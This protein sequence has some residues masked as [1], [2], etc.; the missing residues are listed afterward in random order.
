M[1]TN[2]NAAAP[3]VP[4]SKALVSNGFLFISGQIGSAGGQLVTTSFQDEVRQVFTNIETVL[5]E[6]NLTFSHIV[7]VT[8]Y[9]TDMRYFDELNAVYQTYFTDRYPTRTCI[10][11]AGLPKQARVELTTMA[12]LELEAN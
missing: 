6:H 11:V 8:V 12:S 4:I 9:L 1:S 5:N 10:A 3:A 7:S 2:E